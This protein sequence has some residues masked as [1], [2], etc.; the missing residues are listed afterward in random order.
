MGCFANFWVIWGYFGKE[1]VFL[2]VFVKFREVKN[3]EDLVK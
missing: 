1:I 2:K 3:I